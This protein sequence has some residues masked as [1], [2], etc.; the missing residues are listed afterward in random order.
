M[1]DDQNNNP[2]KVVILSNIDSPSI[3]QAILVLKK[4]FKGSCDKNVIK[5]AEKIIDDYVYSK[6][7]NCNPIKDKA[8]KKN[9]DTMLNIGLIISAI[10][11]VFLICKL[12]IG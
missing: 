3:E 4:G 5:E 8:S 12:C 9:I 6:K 10:G 7:Y 11:V 1:S 2:R